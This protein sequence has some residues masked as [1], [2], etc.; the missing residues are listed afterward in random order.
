VSQT[1][2]FAAA[3]NAVFL[4]NFTRVDAAQFV[5]FS[6]NRSARVNFENVFDEGYFASAHNNNNISPG[7]P[8]SAY[9]TVKAKF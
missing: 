9:V 3:D 4:P 8:R 5:D 2:Q 6:E 1:E 7:A